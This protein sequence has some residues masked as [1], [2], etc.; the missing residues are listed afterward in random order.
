MNTQIINNKTK[1][2]KM[3]CFIGLAIGDALCG[4]YEFYSKGYTVNKEYEGGV[5]HSLQKGE[6]TDDTSMALCLA[7]SIIDN[8]GFNPHD[9]MSKYLKWYKD[10]YM[11]RKTANWFEIHK[12]ADKLREVVSTQAELQK[13]VKEIAIAK[14]TPAEIEVLG[15]KV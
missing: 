3:G 7:Q 12:E 4:P 6:W 5:Y 10:G 9:Q 2:K 15:I 14:L 1:N 8:K 11:S 13:R